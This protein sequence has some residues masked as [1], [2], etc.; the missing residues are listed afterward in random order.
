MH[1]DARMAERDRLTVSLDHSITERVDRVSECRN[2]SR[3]ATLER[4]V[5]NGIDEEEKLLGS[6]GKGVEGR[7]LAMVLQSP[8]I[9][10]GLGKLLKEEADLEL[11]EKIKEGGPGVVAAGKRFRNYNRSPDKDG[12]EE[13]K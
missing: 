6:I 3:A 12:S 1:H 8:R 11:L 9:L 4:I 13:A 7:I 5:L 2:E 10:N